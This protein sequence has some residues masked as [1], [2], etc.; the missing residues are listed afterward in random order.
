[1]N[2]A[3]SMQNANVLDKCLEDNV[4][5]QNEGKTHFHRIDSEWTK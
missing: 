4:K 3:N 1:M 2:E 5:W